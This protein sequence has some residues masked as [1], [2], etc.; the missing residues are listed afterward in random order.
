MITAK[1]AANRTEAVKKTQ[2]KAFEALA[3]ERILESIE[4]GSNVTVIGTMSLQ[5][6]QWRGVSDL[7]I[8]A[9]AF[10][11]ITE[12]YGYKAEF[13]GENFIKITW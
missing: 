9:Y 10:K 1:T 3:E 13:I 6:L 8:K 7:K 2:I 12:N 5:Q 11:Q 4:K